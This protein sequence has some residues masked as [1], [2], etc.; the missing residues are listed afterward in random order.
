MASLALLAFRVSFL[1]LSLSSREIDDFIASSRLCTDFP[2]FACVDFI[3][4]LL[5]LLQKGIFHFFRRLYY[6]APLALRIYTFL[7]SGLGESYIKRIFRLV[8]GI[9][10]FSV[11]SLCEFVCVCVFFSAVSTRVSWESFS[12]KLKSGG[13][14]AS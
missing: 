8:T 13:D 7:L 1:P 9:I 2:S 6:F 4:F 14:E 10:D 12:D 3:V 11:R 5:L